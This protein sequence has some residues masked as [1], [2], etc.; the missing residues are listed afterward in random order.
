[1][2]ARLFKSTRNDI[3]VNFPAKDL[4][5]AFYDSFLAIF[6]PKSIII[7]NRKNR[8]GMWVLRFGNSF[9][10]CCSGW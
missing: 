3:L 6:E 10:D 1:M 4:V 9:G 2:S 8:C 5:L 7:Q